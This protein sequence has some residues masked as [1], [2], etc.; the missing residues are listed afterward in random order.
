MKKIM[1]ACVAVAMCAITQAASVSWA[2]SGAKDYADKNVYAITGYS[3]A[4]VVSFFESSTEADWSKALVGAT[5]AVIGRRGSIEGASTDV[6]ST[7]VFAIIDSAVADGN[8][9]L[10]SGDIS[11]SGYTYE[12]TATPPGTLDFT[13]SNFT[14]TGTFTAAAIPEPTSGL[15]LLLGMAGLA[16]KRKRA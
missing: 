12:G 8:K 3:A 4:E 2:L 13:M 7:I 6:G 15:L 11:T 14:S 10:V 5:S 9:W 16:L 1:I